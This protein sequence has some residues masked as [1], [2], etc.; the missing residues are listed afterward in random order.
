MESFIFFNLFYGYNAGVFRFDS[1][2][3]LFRIH[4]VLTIVGL[5]GVMRKSAYWVGMVGGCQIRNNIRNKK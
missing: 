5:T 3:F 2:P 4:I 1:S